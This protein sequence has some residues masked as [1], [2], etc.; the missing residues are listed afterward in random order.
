MKRVVITGM[1]LVTALGH[2][3]EETW[4]AL[5]QG[6]SG[7]GPIRNFDASEY[8][9]RFAGEVRNFDPSCYLEY[10]EIRRNDPFTHLA[11][12]ASRHALAQAR[13]SISE[14]LAPHIGVCIGSSRSGLSNVHDPLPVLHVNV[15]H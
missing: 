6:R 11:V 8:P 7:I 14:Q 3:V 12:A 15:P 1:G 10:K 5:C 9:V 13:L 2:T 4:E